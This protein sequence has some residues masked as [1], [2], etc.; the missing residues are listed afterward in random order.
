MG[1]S[2]KSLKYVLPHSGNLLGSISIC[3]F[4]CLKEKHDHIKV[5]LDLPRYHDQKLAI[6]VDLKMVKILL[7]QQRRYT[8]YSRFLLLWGSQ[9]YR[10]IDAGQS[11]F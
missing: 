9:H 11:V 6:C 10:N 4:I 7:D 2:K 1:N 8:K 5:V 3:P